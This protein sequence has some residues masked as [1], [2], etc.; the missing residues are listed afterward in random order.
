MKRTAWCVLMVSERSNFEN[1]EAAPKLACSLREIVSR[2]I[3]VVVAPCYMC[4][5]AVQLHFC[6]GSE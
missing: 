4:T 1:L 2:G 6:P 3:N 5:D